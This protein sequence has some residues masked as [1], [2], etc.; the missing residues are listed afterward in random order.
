[1]VPAP[2]RRPWSWSTASATQGEHPRATARDCTSTSTWSPSTCATAAAAPATQTTAGRAR[3]EG[4]A[5]DHRLAGADEA[6]RAPRRARATRWAPA[7]AIA[8]ARDDPRVEALALDSMHTRLVYQ[9]E[10]RLQHTRPSRLPGDVGDLPG[11]SHPNR[12]RRRIDRR[13]RRDP[14]LAGRPI[15]LTHGTADTEDLP[16]R[17][18]SFYE[19]LSRR[20]SMSSCTGAREPATT[21]QPACRCRV[22][23]DD[24]AAWT[25]DFFSRT[26]A[27]A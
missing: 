13:G 23:H 17:T 26:L 1:M 4:P 27:G 6:S 21:R 2:P 20:G 10:Q 19:T 8:E 3:A 12:P 9:V 14:Q 7:T 24:F 25:R 15:L 18:Q 16:A 22:C 11:D 5:R